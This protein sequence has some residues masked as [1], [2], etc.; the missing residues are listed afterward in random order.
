MTSIVQYIAPGVKPGNGDWEAGDRV[1]L[2]TA[3]G[4]WELGIVLSSGVPRFSGGWNKFARDN[5]LS[6]NE[7]VDF[8]LIQEDNKFI[9]VVGFPERFQAVGYHVRRTF[10]FLVQLPLC[11]LTT[12][13]LLNISQL[14][15]HCLNSYANDFVSD[16]VCFMCNGGSIFLDNICQISVSYCV[17]ECLIFLS[18]IT[19]KIGVHKN[20]GKNRRTYILILLCA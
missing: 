13:S 18:K 12:N 6:F 16:Y 19:E 5:L 11:T 2:R 8:N 3:N 14:L 7:T 20:D 15:I 17:L 10:S 9:F 4:E 1:N